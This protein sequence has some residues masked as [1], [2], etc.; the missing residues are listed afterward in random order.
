[1]EKLQLGKSDLYVS[2]VGLGCMGF[3]HASGDPTAD[4]EAIEMLRAAHEIGYDF[5]DT[6]EAY[7]GVKPDGTISYNEEGYAKA[8][9]LLDLLDA[10]AN[11][12]GCTKAQLSLAWMINKEPHIIPIP[13]TRKLH[14]L[15]ENFGAASVPMTAEEIALID[16]KLDTMDFD[17]FGGHAAK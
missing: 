17:V 10:M 3:S 2:P 12:K 6:A 5:Y 16:A 9:A 7:V 1:M 15:K 11:E 4:D 8:K 14:R 13:G